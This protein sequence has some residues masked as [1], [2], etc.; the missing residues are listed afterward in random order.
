MPYLESVEQADDFAQSARDMMRKLGVPANP[1]NFT[2]WYAYFAGMRADLT[3]A[4]DTLIGEQAKFT[5]ERNEELYARYFTFDT[6]GMEI[7]AATDQIQLT[8]SDVLE[9]LEDAQN[10]ASSYADSLAAVSGQLSEGANAAQVRS[11][12]YGILSETHQ[13]VQKGKLLEARLED[14]SGRIDGL[15]QQIVD[16]SRAATTDAL[17]NIANRT[18][19]DLRLRETVASAQDTGHPVSVVLTDID[20]FK[21]F[22]DKFGRRIGDEVLK[23]VAHTL[24]EGL[25]ERDTPARFGGEEFAII[26]PK[27]RLDDAIATA[28]RLCRTLS[29][30]RIVNRTSGESFGSVTLSFG[31]AQY[32]PGEALDTLVLRAE[33]ALLLAK[34]NG[35]NTVVSEDDLESIAANANEPETSISTL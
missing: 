7:T 16:I 26:L 12:V 17:T 1:T 4:I 20:N 29:K 35:R 30:K 34:R 25:K 24:E 2:V 6:H 32:H 22:N 33:E 23:I 13:M 11:L 28:D 10:D 8:V 9:N 21:H 5:A 15:K 3:E 14:S 31:V 27:T 19:F 18:Y